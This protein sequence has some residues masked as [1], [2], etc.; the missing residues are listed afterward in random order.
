MPDGF[1]HRALPHFSRH[2]RDPDAK[3]FVANSFYSGLNPPEFFFH[4]M[5]GREGL[6]D[7][8]VKTA[9]TGYMARR[10]MKALE[11]LTAHYDGSVRNS[12]GNIVQYTYGDDGLDPA[13]MEAK[14]GRPINFERTLHNEQRRDML[15]EGGGS[16][17][18]RVSEPAEPILSGSALH[19]LLERHIG[20]QQFA[21]TVKRSIPDEPTKYEIELRTFVEKFAASLDDLDDLRSEPSHRRQPCPSSSL[22]G[23]GKAEVMPARRVEPAW[24]VDAATCSADEEEDAATPRASARTKRGRRVIVDSDDD[25][26]ATKREVDNQAFNADPNPNATAIADT[27]ADGDVGADSPPQPV[28]NEVAMGKVACADTD[29]D[30]SLQRSRARLSRRQAEAF[31]RVCL[32]KYRAA[33][34]QPGSAVGAV[35]AQSIG[36]PGTQMTLKTFHFAGVASM[37]ITLGVPRIKEIINAAKT[38]STPIIKAQLANPYD[39]E[40]ARVVKGCIERTLL[41]GVRNI[42]VTLPDTQDS[43]PCTSHLSSSSRSR[44]T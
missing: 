18:T 3:G 21:A 2:S 42:S 11:D 19:A 22:V 36:E 25:D 8:A 44:R 33:R 37:N 7:T 17:N 39:E 10:L 23:G 1:I 43:F 38:I 12:E 27:D 32:S 24:R 4:T 35:G 28:L 40:S 29:A 13:M 31:L 30:S 26:D 20:S 41:G 16:G 5:G 34:I 15:A 6:V 14:D 9:E